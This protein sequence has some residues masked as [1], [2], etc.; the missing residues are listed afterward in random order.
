M[1]DFFAAGHAVMKR[2]VCL[3]IDVSELIALATFPRNAGAAMP[4]FNPS[5]F[6]L[7]LNPFRQRWLL[8]SDSGHDLKW[9]QFRLTRLN[10]P[11]VLAAIIPSIRR[12]AIHKPLAV[13]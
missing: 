13:E 11:I 1:P 7:R 8:L 3:W 10:E 2:S 5:P 4:E 6:G 9:R 12:L